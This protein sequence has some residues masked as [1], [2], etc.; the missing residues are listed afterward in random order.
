M[1][2]EM[3]CIHR[4]QAESYRPFRR[5]KAMKQQIHISHMKKAIELTPGKSDSTKMRTTMKFPI[6]KIEM[7]VAPLALMSAAFIVLAYNRLFWSSL[8]QIIDIGSVKADSSPS[9]PAIPPR[10]A[11]TA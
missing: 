8:F 9:A 3:L 11:T 10:T 1:S 5:L 4:P 2:A 7:S 6:R